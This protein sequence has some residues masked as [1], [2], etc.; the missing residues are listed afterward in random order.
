MY[1]KLIFFIFLLWLFPAELS[2]Q[3]HPVNNPFGIEFVM[4]KPG[5]VI[6][7]R[8]EP[9]VGKYLKPENP[10]EKVLSPKAYQIAENMAKKAAMPG[11]KV[12]INR[13]FYIGKYE[14]TQLQ[15]KQV[16]GNNP[17]WFQKEKVSGDA[18]RHPVENISW[19]NAQAFIR[20]LNKLDKEHFYR[21]PTEFEWE[22]AA[23]AGAQDDI[24]WSKAF[25]IGVI[26]DSTSRPVG[27]KQPNEW[28][29]YDMIGNVWEWVQDAY[30]EKIFADPIPS[31]S[32][33]EHVLKGASF[34]GDAKNAT[35]KTHAAGPGN[36]Y[37]VGL[38]L[39]LEI[40]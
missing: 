9:T 12:S 23:A 40:R 33:T 34:T 3:N 38:R 19:K 7:G 5:H 26:S 25:E 30:N 35:Y 1:H 14:I 4:I 11:F 16:M 20:K 28:G 21:L 24:L 2:A 22:Y 29:L 13:A 8:Y 37:D 31:R 18:N 32:G 39:V 15:W 6:I 36:G 17:S 27:S 10:D